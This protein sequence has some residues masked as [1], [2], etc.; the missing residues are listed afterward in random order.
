M[1]PVFLWA[2]RNDGSVPCRNSLILAQGLDEVGADFA[3][4]LYRRG[5]HGLAT[6]DAL[7]FPAG[8]LPE[9]SWD[10]PGWPEAMLAFFR[11]VGL[12]IRDE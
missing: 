3:F 8:E 6:A 9:M 7:A 10:V 4:H 5:K 1:P 12:A 11:D 2:T